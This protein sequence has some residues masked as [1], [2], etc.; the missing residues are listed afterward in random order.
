M[1]P[2]EQTCKVTDLLYEMS[3]GLQAKEW[4]TRPHA[5]SGAVNTGGGAASWCC[6]GS[7][8]RR[9]LLDKFTQREVVG[10]AGAEHGHAINDDDRLRH[11]EFGDTRCLG[12]A[13]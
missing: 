13:D 7:G 1:R 6:T 2:R 5:L 10:L 3:Q 12:V 4:L 8:G 11:H 9:T